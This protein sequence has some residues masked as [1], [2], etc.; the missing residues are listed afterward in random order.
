[1]YSDEF[2]DAWWNEDKPHD[3]IFNLV[4]YIKQQQTGVLAR[5]IRNARLYSNSEITGLTPLDYKRKAISGNNYDDAAIR[6]NVVASVCDTISSK[7]AKQKPHVVFMP[8]A[9]DFKVQQRSKKLERFVNGI[10][11]QTDIYE[12]ATRAFM[13]SLLFGTGVLKVYEDS[14]NVCIERV[15]PSELVVDDAEG[16][17]GKPRQM[18]QTKIIA[19]DILNGMFPGFEEEIESATIV[20]RNSTGSGMDIANSVTV[21]ESW[22]L[23]SGPDTGDGRHTITVDGATLFD[24]DYNNEDFPFVFMHWKKPVVGFFGLG[25]VTDIVGIQVEINKLLMKVQQAFHK[26]ANPM[27]FVKQG[28]SVSKAKIS[29]DIGVIIPYIGTPPLVSVAQTVHPEVFQHIERLYSRAFEI[30]GVSQLSAT[31]RKP[32]GL[33]SGTALREYNDVQSERFALASM[34]YEAMFVNIAKKVIG[35]ARDMYANKKNISAQVKG[36]KFVENIKWSDVSLNDEQFAITVAAASSL[37]DTKAGRVQVATEWVNMQ[38]VSKEE[39]RELLDIPDLD[40]ATD[41]ARAPRD[42]IRGVVDAIMTE[43]RYIPPEPIDDIGFAM[44]YSV[45][46]YSRAKLEGASEESLELLMQYIDDVKA[47]QDEAKAKMMAE[48]QEMAMAQAPKQAPAQPKPVIPEN[49]VMAQ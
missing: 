8:D 28:S 43:N 24:E 18:H 45:M 42:Y 27:V 17:Y 36:K 12:E 23:K 41:L 26:L 48:Q 10:F 3:D 1:M 6:L 4:D 21:V 33:D 37:P 16:F 11:Y 9:A 49:P 29:N 22:H 46:I 38:L 31:A 32:E 15:L 5:N 39:W 14:D 25:V 34:N 2:V 20:D 7:L 47:L 13:D 30:A 35:L 40:D 44:E 19:R